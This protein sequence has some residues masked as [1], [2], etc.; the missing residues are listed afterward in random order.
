[1]DTICVITKVTFHIR[2]VNISGCDSRKIQN[3]KSQFRHSFYN[4]PHMFHRAADMLHVHAAPLIF[5]KKDK[6]EFCCL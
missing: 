3:L 2:D 1:M 6:Y 5:R 4:E